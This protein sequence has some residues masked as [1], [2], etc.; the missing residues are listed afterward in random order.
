MAENSKIK[1]RKL[2]LHK[3]AVY[4][5]LMMEIRWFMFMISIVRNQ[6]IEL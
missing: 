5:W 1:T 2:K 4:I 6:V 3:V